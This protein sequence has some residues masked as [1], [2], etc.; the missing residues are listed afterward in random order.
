M[1]NDHDYLDY[2][3][4]L[5][6]MACVDAFEITTIR[7][8]SISNLDRWESNGTWCSAFDEWRAIM[9]SGSDADVI[10]AMTG[11]DQRANRLRQSSPYAG[12]IDR[13]IRASIVRRVQLLR[14][15]RSN[16]DLSCDKP[17]FI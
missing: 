7:Q 1:H 11:L 6:A 13:N 12:L 15:S 5:V 2:Q 10:A 3:K 9:T 14:A 17:D 16:I 8:W 4:L